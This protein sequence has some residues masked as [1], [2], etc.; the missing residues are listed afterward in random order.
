MKRVFGVCLSLLVATGCAAS[1][2][3]ELASAEQ[4][5]SA[6]GAEMTL[7]RFPNN[8]GT[9]LAHQSSPDGVVTV[10]QAY[11]SQHLFGRDL[12]LDLYVAN[13]GAEKQIWVVDER[14]QKSTEASFAGDYW[15][16]NG[17]ASWRFTTADDKDNIVVRIKG[18]AY[19]EQPYS[20]YVK[21]NGQ[22]HE[23]KI[24]LGGG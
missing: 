8:T 17:A 16:N 4:D 7:D 11:V 23:S 3:A 6:S 18:F 20:I 14:N 1:S 12:V 15:N 5:F 22:T 9:R 10:N 21:M 13:L 19:P 2:G 24:T